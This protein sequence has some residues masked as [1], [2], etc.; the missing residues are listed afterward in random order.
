MRTPT[1]R[2][3]LLLAACAWPVQA[4]AQDRGH[5]DETDAGSRHSRGRIADIEPYIEAGQ[6]FVSELEPGND[7]VTYTEVAAGVDATI[8]GRESAASVSLRYERR[9][10]WGDDADDS[11]TVSGIA[12]ASIALAP[13]A[14]T[15]EAGGLAARTRVEGNG[16]ATFG[17]V[18]ANEDSSSQLYAGYIG[19]SVHTTAGDVEI[20]G[21]YRFG[22]TRVESPDVLTVVPGNPPADIF[23][24]STVHMAA[25]RIG[26]R[27]YTGGLPIGVGIG[28]GWN[29]QNVSNL[30]Q[31]I[32][33]RHVRGDVIVP[34]SPNIAVVGGV[35]YEDVEV[36]SR[37]ARRDAAGNP[38][39]GADG[40][41]VTDETAPRRI[42]YDTDGLIWDAG[43]M[44]R[45]SPRTSLEAY[46]GRR[47]GSTTYWGTF[48]WAPDRRQSFNVV[49]Y[50]NLTGFGGLVVD[51]LARLPAQFDA[52]RNP[53][54]GEIGGCVAGTG[55]TDASQLGGGTCIAGAL[56]SV[57][58]AVFRSRGVA[59]SYGLELGRAQLGIGGGYDRRKF[60]AA[61]GTVL[62]PANGVVDESAWLAA[63]ASERLDRQSTVAANAFVNWFDSGFGVGAEA[64][65]YSASLAYTRDFLNHLSGTAAVGLDGITREDLPD[66]ATASALLGLR[67]SF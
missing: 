46:V 42:A 17:G 10:G 26:T 44:W 65:G 7:T 41:F 21:H 35:G 19:P 30:D 27:P 60:I 39:I 22:Y 13:R 8:A 53:I 14:V 47:Y 51:T 1:L 38:V 48:A 43:V 24:E 52:F 40:R 3:A 55:G 23:D 67:Y 54:T 36:S 12:R 4:M 31:R 5:D 15:L 33:D 11:D 18:L 45:P 58:S 32:R 16:G 28:G 57:R 37:D 59:A 2:L 66:V 63:Y 20:E 62:A 9:F 49:V 61:A 50:D 25:A 6:V 56:S 29:E 34:V 64:I